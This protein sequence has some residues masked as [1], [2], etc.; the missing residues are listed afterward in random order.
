MQPVRRDGGAPHPTVW[1]VGEPTKQLAAYH[2]D[3]DRPLWSIRKNKYFG[4]Y[5]RF[6]A[7]I[8]NRKGYLIEI[9]FK[10]TEKE[11]KQPA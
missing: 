3:I 9:S 5:S 11:E 6:P 1:D 10:I 2:L 7:Q 8:G 4:C